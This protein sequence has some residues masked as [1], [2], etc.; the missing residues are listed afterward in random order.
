[1]AA[2]TPP[3]TSPTPLTDLPE[4]VLVRLLELMDDDD[5]YVLEWTSKSLRDL[6]VSPPLVQTRRMKADIQDKHWKR[7]IL[8]EFSHCPEALREPWRPPPPQ[9]H[10]WRCLYRRFSKPV[11]VLCHEYDG[12]ITTITGCP[13]TAHPLKEITG[14]LRANAILAVDTK[15]QAYTTQV[16]WDA[17]KSLTF[18]AVPPNNTKEISNTIRYAML[19]SEDGALWAK[20]V[21]D[22]VGVQDGIR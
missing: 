15:N 16:H 6:T 7:R 2:S 1:M 14:E 20:E 8:A 9:A 22:H 3:P 18:H 10:Y 11:A 17:G 5:V 13:D 21:G 19:L 12:A 4:P